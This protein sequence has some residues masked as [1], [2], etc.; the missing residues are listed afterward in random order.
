M[1]NTITESVTVAQLEQELADAI[2]SVGGDV[3]GLPVTDM[4]EYIENN[5]IAES[6]DIL[7]GDGIL[8]ES[9]GSN[10]TIKSTS[11][12]LL[13]SNI[14]ALPDSIT[15]QDALVALTQ[16]LS[17]TSG[18]QS[19]SVIRTNA[20]GLDEEYPDVTDL[21]ENS[22]YIRLILSNGSVLHISAYEIDKALS[23]IAQMS[24]NKASQSDVDAL[25]IALDS[26][27]SAAQVTLL[28]SD[29]AGKADKTAVADLSASVETKADK[30]AVADLSASVETKADK[31]TVADLSASVE[32]KADKTTVADLSASVETKADKTTVAEMQADVEA[33]EAALNSLSDN[34]T[35]A[36]ITA[37][38][39]YLNDEINRRLTIDDLSNITNS[40]AEINNKIA[41][42]TKRIGK[43]EDTL[44]SKASIAYVQRNTSELNNAITSLAS[45]FSSKADK[46]EL[47]A[48][49]SQDDLNVLVK[50]IAALNTSTSEGI[51]ELEECCKLVKDELTKKASKT[52]LENLTADINAALDVKADKLDVADSVNLLT[53]TI[54]NVKENFNESLGNL[55]SDMHDV[56]V[57]LNNT[58]SILQSTINVHDR[59]LLEQGDQLERMQEFNYRLEEATR[60]EW[61]RVMTPEEY[62]RLSNVPNY[63]GDPY[64]KKPNVLYMLVRFNKP[65]AIYIGTILIAQARQDGSVGFAYDFP[66]IF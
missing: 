34:N 4:P 31:T 14:D 41:D 65:I 43:I 28:E 15:I 25:T 2:N 12:G 47:A 36:A 60:N 19:G 21:L 1:A 61:V 64:A 40:D 63:D 51:T 29:L 57:G 11:D 45:R 13:S 22:F 33:L 59:K 9:D 44:T 38:I 52:S 35:I 32:T 37:Q 8:V 49:A 27:A 5:L 66:I 23:I 6:W 42:N 3:T 62:N 10:Y 50:R 17:N 48:K 7:G 30:T 24:D 18:I 55:S 56:E 53:N 39:N 54:T 58:M 26:K 20:D 46:V 16:K